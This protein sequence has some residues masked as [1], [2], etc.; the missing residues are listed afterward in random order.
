[1]SL[2]TLLGF[3]SG[4][5]LILV[6]IFLSTTNFLLFLNIPSVLIVFGGTI[7]SA[8]ISYQAVYVNKALKQTFDIY[9]VAKIDRNI[10]IDELNSSLKWADIVH[11]EGPVGLDN[12]LK[13]EEPDDRLLSFGIDLILRQYEPEEIRELMTNT[14]NSEFQRS[15]IQSGILNNMGGNAP[16]FGMVGTLIGLVVM[17]D[18]LGPNPE[19]IGSA[20]A[21]AL[22][23]TLYGVLVARL[24]FQPAAKKVLQAGGI[25]RYRNM[26]MMEIFVM[27]S[28]SRSANYIRDRIRSFLAPD[29][30]NKIISPA[31]RDAAT[32]GD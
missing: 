11:K 16:A 28:E 27:I 24:I 23:T 13:N 19:Q 30:L 14:I 17:L 31:E 32:E 25:E 4:I 2:G 9:K 20:L 7:A 22:L 10:L 3:L 8:Y 29:M 1:M 21:V 18:N 6:S 15:K 5:A 26:L 12:Y